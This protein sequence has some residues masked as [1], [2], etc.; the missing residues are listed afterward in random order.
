MLA[1]DDLDGFEDL[2]ATMEEDSVEFKIQ[3]ALLKA[4][5]G[6]L[7]PAA[8]DLLALLKQSEQDEDSGDAYQIER[9][10]RQVLAEAN[11]QA[12]LV[13]AFPNEERFW[14]V[15]D[16][17]IRTQDWD[18]CEDLLRTRSAALRD[19]RRCLPFLVNWA[20]GE[21]GVLAT[22]NESV[23][24]IPVSNSN[25]Q[26]LYEPIVKS[27]ILENEPER[28]RTWANRMADSAERRNALIAIEMHNGDWSEAVKLLRQ[29]DAD[30]RSYLP[31]DKIY[32][33]DTAFDNLK[34]ADLISPR[35]VWN[36]PEV[37]DLRLKFLF[38]ES[39]KLDSEQ[40]KTLFSDAVEGELS[41]K[42]FPA[43]KDGTSWISL[44]SDDVELV[45]TILS[46]DYEDNSDSENSSSRTDENR[47]QKNF[48]SA[49]TLVLLTVVFKESASPAKSLQL[50]DRLA[51]P[52]CSLK[53]LAFGRDYYWLD[54]SVF[55][56]WFEAKK[57]D[58]KR[59][60]ATKECKGIWSYP[61]EEEAADVEAKSLDFQIELS[62]ALKS[63]LASNDDSKH[64]DVEVTATD[65]MSR[66][67]V[68]V[69]RVK[70]D[71]YGNINLIGTAR[72][73]K[74]VPQVGLY[75]GQLSIPIS[76]IVSFNAKLD[77]QTHAAQLEP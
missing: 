73:A 75:R 6:Q 10:L 58:R 1:D 60:F 32:W 43:A 48:A 38:A 28:A 67:L 14:Q 26:R 70:R 33:T 35:P 34:V 40:L 45:F 9:H 22:L 24:A 54:Q 50:A 46:V 17:L 27:C 3:S 57:K 21:F 11:D 63:F 44:S 59:L 77:Q 68:R 15:A 4:R 52:M 65:S 47:M 55:E 41:V 19:A 53:P 66:Y 56:S 5:R 76:Q 7:Q 12:R 71:S 36:V 62:S 61:E 72:Y 69:N 2:L 30:E 8:D 37:Y 13:R 16:D 25:L 51:R 42:T 20:Q 29:M 23:D 74:D 49:R 64:F 39:P 18:G 31:S